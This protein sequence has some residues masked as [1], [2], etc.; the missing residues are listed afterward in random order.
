MKTVSL[1]KYNVIFDEN[2]HYYIYEFDDQVEDPGYTIKWDDEEFSDEETA[3]TRA[4]E[5]TEE[6]KKNGK[7]PIRMQINI[8]RKTS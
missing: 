7:S 8:S 3:K 1:P 4:R 6:A 5:L 2:G